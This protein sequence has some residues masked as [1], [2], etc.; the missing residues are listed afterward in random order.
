M[1]SERRKQRGST[2]SQR[3]WS[4]RGIPSRGPIRIGASGWKVLGSVQEERRDVRVLID[5]TGA[6]VDLVVDNHVQVLLGVVGGD[7]LESEFL[8]SRHGDGVVE[9]KP[10]NCAIAKGISPLSP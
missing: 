2:N 9:R 8:C 5:E 7:L 4:D 3:C 6:V 10:E 1:K